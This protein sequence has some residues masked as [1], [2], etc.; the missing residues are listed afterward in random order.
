[1]TSIPSQMDDS[2]AGAVAQATAGDEAAFA[3]LVRAH[4]GDVTR[5][6]DC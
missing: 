1:M 5:G 2:L 3:R 4:H 6:G